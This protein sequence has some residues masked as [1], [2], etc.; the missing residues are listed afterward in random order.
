MLRTFPQR[1]RKKRMN[2]LI[3]GYSSS[4]VVDELKTA[5][6]LQ[7][8]PRRNRQNDSLRSWS[9]ETK[10]HVTDFLAPFFI[11]EGHGLKTEVPNFPG[12]CRYSI[13]LLLKEIESLAKLGVP[14]ILLFPVISPELKDAEGSESINPN[15]LIQR[16]VA[17]VSKEFPDICVMADVALDPYTSHGHDGLIDSYGQVLNDPS[18]VA[19][20][21]LSL[22]LAEA[23]ITYVAP[24]D[25]MDG[26]IAYIRNCL[27]AAGF[28]M[29]GTMSYAAKYASCFYGPFRGA[30]S[31]AKLSNDKKSYQ[32]DPANAREALIESKLD[33][34]E[35]A[36]ILCVKPAMVYLDIIQRIRNQTNLPISAYQVSGEYSM[37]LQAAEKGWLDRDQG[38]WESLVSIKR[39]GANILISYATKEVCENLH[40]GVY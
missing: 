22:S 35:G 11:T 5:P 28:S 18:L 2:T 20:G 33:E 1:L 14:G 13:D 24:S 19:L 15:G 25:M 27:D 21:K 38:L 30:V 39:A 4:D 12:V 26:R 40:K 32:L 31:S 3:R 36:D 16:A 37:I 23:G 29:V 9:R 34:E 17:A 10:L 8:R 6:Y 7:K